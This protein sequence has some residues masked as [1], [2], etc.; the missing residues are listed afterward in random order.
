LNGFDVS[1][2]SS[3]PA[4]LADG[5]LDTFSC[6]VLDVHMPAMS[7]IELLELLRRRA[8]SVPVVMMT[9]RKDAALVERA[10]TC[11]A[12]SFMQKPILEQALIANIQRALASG[13]RCHT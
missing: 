8:I 4:L 2:F 10:C 11:G 5:N 1:A 3:G 13:A 6:L 9:G 12:I 7:G